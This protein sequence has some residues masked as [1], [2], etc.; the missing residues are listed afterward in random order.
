M[1]DVTAIV[2]TMNESANIGACIQS[3]AGFAKRVVVLDSGSTDDTCEI[4]RALGADVMTHTFQYYAAQFN[5]GVE[6]A[7][8]QTEWTLRLDADERFTPEVCARC[9]QLLS[10]RSIRV[11]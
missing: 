7:H 1:A 11:G 4:A 2:L 6:N 3:V 8:I 9:E 5:W 10:V